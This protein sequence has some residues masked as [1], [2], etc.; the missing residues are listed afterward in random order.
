[1]AKMSQSLTKLVEHNSDSGESSKWKLAVAFGV[2][3][4]VVSGLLLYWYWHSR[5]RANSLTS[6]AQSTTVQNEASRP[7]EPA[8]SK[9]KVRCLIYRYH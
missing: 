8:A 1:M 5:R 7:S 9:A 2:P 6:S 3:I 4:A